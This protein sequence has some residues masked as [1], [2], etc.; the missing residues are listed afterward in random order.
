MSTERLIP[1]S[2]GIT[3][4][5]GMRMIIFYMYIQENSLPEEGPRSLTLLYK[6]MKSMKTKADQNEFGFEHRASESPLC[7][8][9]HVRAFELSFDFIDKQLLI[10]DSPN[11]GK[12]IFLYDNL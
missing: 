6:K 7:G 3:D 8:K 5:L 4:F 12:T 2:A 1:A 11:R 10:K 9:M